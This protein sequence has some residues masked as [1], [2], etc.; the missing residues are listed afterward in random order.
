MELMKNPK[1]DTWLEDYDNPM[2]FVASAVRDIIIESDARVSEDLKWQAPTF[3]Y[4]GNI[5]TINPRSKK[6]VSLMFHKGALIDGNFPNLDGDGKEARTFKI[7]DIDD[8]KA[9]QDELT[10]IIKC[11]CN[12]MDGR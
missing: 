8:L 1:I 2:K 9:K 6:H 10:A 4:K 11:W 7:T 5:A 3:M 12:M